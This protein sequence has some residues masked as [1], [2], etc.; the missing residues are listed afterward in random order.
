MQNKIKI[1]RAGDGFSDFMTSFKDSSTTFSLFSYLSTLPEKMTKQT[2]S[3]FFI[4]TLVD[5]AFLVNKPSNR[6]YLD[7]SSPSKS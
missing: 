4:F 1:N 5:S 3:K 2:L 7:R 6:P